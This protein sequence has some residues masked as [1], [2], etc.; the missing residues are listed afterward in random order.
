MKDDEMIQEE[1]S[2][3]RATSS[4]A[5]VANRFS[6]GR[7][8]TKNNNNGQ[9]QGQWPRQSQQN[10]KN[11]TCFNCGGVGQVPQSEWRFTLAGRV[12]SMQRA[13]KQGQE[14]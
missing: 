12:A 8:Y 11:V 9:R 13:Q 1:Q 10:K 5:L 3:I 7:K 14:E 2:E 6:N 4:S